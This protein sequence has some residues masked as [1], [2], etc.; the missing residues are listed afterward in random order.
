[1]DTVHTTLSGTGRTVTIGP[2]LPTVVI[3]ERINP[4]GKK[5]LAEMLGAGDLSLVREM[6]KTQVA[7]G[8]DVLDVNVGLAGGDEVAL[9]RRAVQA[10]AEVVDVPLSIDTA[11]VQALEA[12]LRVAPGRPLINSVSGK[13]KSL[14]A[15]LPLAKE[16]GAVVI[17]LTMDE[18]GISRDA[19][20]RLEIAARIVERAEALGIPRQDVV[21]DCLALTVGAEPQSARVTLE[22]VRLVRE[23]LG[24]NVNLGGSNVSFGLPDRR[25]I[26][27][28]F[29]A[30]AI[31]A[32]M[33]C[34]IADPA[35]V[36]GAVRAADLLLGRD[37]YASRYISHYRTTQKES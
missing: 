22:T 25:V 1:M 12:A 28:A 31:A 24:V 35:Q 23:R 11:N 5:R 10:V 27:Q 3:G 16:Y 37:E 26:N 18:R 9:L 17:G 21:I 19:P 33:T 32:G 34:V 15:V 6:A 13:E 30:M 14:G 4:T 20:A 8:A 7:A 36:C 2:G 29:V